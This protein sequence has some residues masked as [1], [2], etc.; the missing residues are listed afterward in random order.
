M[1]YLRPKGGCETVATD[2]GEAVYWARQ[3]YGMPDPETVRYTV[4]KRGDH[5][6]GIHHTYWVRWRPQ[7]DG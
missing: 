3:L 1:T 7:I 5:P 2:K 4:E 6:D